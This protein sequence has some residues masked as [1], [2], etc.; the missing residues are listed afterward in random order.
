MSRFRRPL[1]AMWRTGMGDLRQPSRAD[2][3]IAAPIKR[4]IP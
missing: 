2:A 1:G 4:P 3:R